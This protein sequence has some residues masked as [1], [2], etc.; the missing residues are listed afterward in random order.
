MKPQPPYYAV[1]FTS[2][3]T[4]KDEGYA[5]M[6]EEMMQ[7][8]SQQPG[9]L[10]VEHARDRVGITISYWESLEAISQWKNQTDHIL[11]QD[12]GKATWYSSYKVRICKVER[13]YGFSTDARKN[14]S[15]K[16]D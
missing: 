13:E 2:I 4:T 14:I 3:R 7:L 6:A 12:L 16:K 10:G 5:R 1:I 9:Y 11:A 15:Q 8:A